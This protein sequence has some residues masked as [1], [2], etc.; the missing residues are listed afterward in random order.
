[1]QWVLVVNH[2]PSSNHISVFITQQHNPV[3]RHRIHST[4][5]GNSKMTSLPVNFLY[6]A[7]NVSSCKKTTKMDKCQNDH[8][9]QDLSCSYTRLSLN[10]CIKYN[11]LPFL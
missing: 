1:M 3:I 2:Q 7:A 9:K 11:V 8:K 6:T 5:S 4:N 10:T